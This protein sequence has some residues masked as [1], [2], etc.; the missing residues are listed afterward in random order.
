[1]CEEKSK[2]KD[3]VVEKCMQI[4][5]EDWSTRRQSLDCI[6]RNP[7]SAC[8]DEIMMMAMIRVYA[9]RLVAGGVWTL[10]SSRGESIERI[11]VRHRGGV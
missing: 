4:V 5:N 1:M 8:E 9:K 3:N 6:I 11:P 7:R 10:R 2:D